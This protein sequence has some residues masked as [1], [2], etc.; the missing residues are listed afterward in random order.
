MQGRR[1][2]EIPREQA[3]VVGAN[4]RALRQRKGWIQAKVG[5]MMGWPTNATVCAAEGHRDGRQ[6]GF[7]A[8]EVKRL[9]EI[10]GISPLRL[11]TRCANCDGHPP[12]GFAC[13]TCGASICAAGYESIVHPLFKAREHHRITKE[14]VEEDKRLYNIDRLDYPGISFIYPVL[15]TTGRIY[16]VAVNGSAQPQVEEVRWTTLERVFNPRNLRSAMR[17]DVVNFNH[18]QTYLSERVFATVNQA[19][20]TVKANAHLY[21]PEWLLANFGEPR[22]AEPFNAWLEATRRNGKN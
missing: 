14:S 9:A 15:L 18:F 4:I 17:L 7:T 1:R 19:F 21:D 13:L 3:A 6:R 20:L 2:E 16:T 12:A 10:F 22:Y 8:D 11:T 5:E